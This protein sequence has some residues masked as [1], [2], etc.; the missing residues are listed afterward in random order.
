L[1]RFLQR[2]PLGDGRFMFYCS[3]H[4]AYIGNYETKT[5]FIYKS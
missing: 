1:N 4:V 2:I 5:L 3:I